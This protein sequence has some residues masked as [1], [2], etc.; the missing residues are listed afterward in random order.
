MAPAQHHWKEKECRVS[1]GGTDK[2]TVVMRM[3][4][5]LDFGSWIKLCSYMANG[6]R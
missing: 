2:L 4:F 5:E 3:V 1:K 6:G